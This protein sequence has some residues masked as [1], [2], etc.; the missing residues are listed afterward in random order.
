MKKTRYNLLL[1]MGL[2]TA[3]AGAQ[4]FKT[5][6]SE[7]QVNNQATISIEASY[8]EIEIEELNRNRVEVQG[9]MQIEGL[10]ECIP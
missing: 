8:T 3:I 10:S 1:A 2:F 9:V 4:E 6:V 7:F 5:P